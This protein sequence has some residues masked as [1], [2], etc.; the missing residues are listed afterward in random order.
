MQPTKYTFMVYE[1]IYYLN[2]LTYSGLLGHRQ[3]YRLN[4]KDG[5]QVCFIYV[6]FIVVK[7]CDDLKDL[8][9]LSMKMTEKAETRRK[10]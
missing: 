8:H 6:Y 10:Y 9:V 2:S 3:A 4:L 7:I 1:Y 5:P